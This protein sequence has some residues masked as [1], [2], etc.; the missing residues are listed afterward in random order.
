MARSS[1]TW[2][3]GKSG[4]P[5]GRP[6]KTKFISE[7]INDLM[8]LSLPE[9]NKVVADETAPAGKRIAA[10]QVLRAME[11]Q[12][13]SVERVIN[14]TEGKVPDKLEHTEVPLEKL[15]DAELM[16]RA[17]EIAARIGQAGE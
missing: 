2:P 17:K 8:P 10:M 15:D 11:G 6:P 7:Y 14:R 13:D 4:N 1:T 9:V 12:N 3:P 5:P 16:R